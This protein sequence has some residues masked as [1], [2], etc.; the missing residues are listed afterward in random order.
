MIE[1]RASQSVSAHFR[2]CGFWCRE[3]GASVIVIGIWSDPVEGRE[4]SQ[5]FTIGRR[6]GLAT[7]RSITDGP[8]LPTRGNQVYSPGG[9]W[10]AKPASAAFSK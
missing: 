5:L 6:R 9:L 3:G 2:R 8:P 1:V 4:A 7:E 10:R